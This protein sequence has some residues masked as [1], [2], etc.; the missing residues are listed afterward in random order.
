MSK[1][2]NVQRLRSYY[3]YYCHS[4]TRS[5]SGLLKVP[6]ACLENTESRRPDISGQSAVKLTLA[7]WLSLLFGEMPPQKILHCDDLHS[8]RAG[9]RGFGQVFISGDNVKVAIFF[10]GDCLAEEMKVML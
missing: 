6:R 1:Y 9:R 2:R 10:W 5:K 8:S 3:S 7:L 4:S